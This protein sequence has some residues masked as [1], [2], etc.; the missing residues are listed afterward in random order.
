MNPCLKMTFKVVD[1][2]RMVYGNFNHNYSPF[3]RK[4]RNG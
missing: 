2:K 3:R 4:K 1:E